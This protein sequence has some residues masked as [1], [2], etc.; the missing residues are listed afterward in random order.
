[1]RDPNDTDREGTWVDEDEPIADYPH[2]TS[3]G[4]DLKQDDCH[5]EACGWAPSD[6]AKRTLRNWFG[7]IHSHH[8]IPF[9]CG[10]EET[11]ENIVHLC[12]ICHA[13]AHQLGSVRGAQHQRR[14]TWEGIDTRE[15][16][17]A[18][19]RVL[20]HDEKSAGLSAPDSASPQTAT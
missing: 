20:R 4:N 5:C 8:I 15:Q 6:F 9:S 7:L 13:M 1:M 3:L 12:P 2:R 17:L 19:L 10:G 14:K 18:S 16:L 11:P